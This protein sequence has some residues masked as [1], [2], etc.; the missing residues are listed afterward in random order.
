MGA[1]MMGEIVNRMRRIVETA[2]SDP[3]L[4]GTARTAR[5]L[6]SE[7]NTEADSD[8]GFEPKRLVP[9]YQRRK[10]HLESRN[11]D[12]GGFTQTIDFFGKQDSQIEI[13][14]C[15]ASGYWVAVWLN[16]T[17]QEEIGIMYVKQIPRERRVS[18][19]EF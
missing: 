18:K 14:S 8:V 12:H 5:R 13:L 15:V 17:N 6:L 4:G 11:I 1:Q 19:K 10:K 7:P 9:I 16:P 2:C 3:T